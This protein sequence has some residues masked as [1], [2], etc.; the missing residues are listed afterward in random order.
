MENPGIDPGTSRMQSGR[1]TTWLIPQSNFYRPPFSGPIVY[2]QWFNI[3]LK[4][5]FY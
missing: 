3:I 4:G 1:S 2:N 5:Q